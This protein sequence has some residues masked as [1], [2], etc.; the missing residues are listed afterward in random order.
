MI[1]EALCMGLFNSTSQIY[2][3]QCLSRGTTERG[4]AR[5]MKLTFTIGPLAAVAGSLGT[6]FV[7]NGG[8]PSLV[9]PRDF[10][11]LVHFYAVPCAAITAWCCSRFELE[12]IA[13]RPHSSFLRQL[14]AG[15]RDFRGS[16]ALMMLF[17]G[18]L[19]W[20]AA[21]FGIANL[22][23]YT[24]EAMGREPADFAGVMLA[25]CVARPARRWPVSDSASS[26]WRYE[27]SRAAHRQ[28][29]G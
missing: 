28:R 8:I 13:E 19:L 2:M 14:S 4:R 3:F 22:S 24:K 10:A 1:A 18:Y 7:L 25:P 21:L 29:W 20:N 17:F 6:Q 23:L 12:P 15:F 5:A 26:I 9:F 11:L 16:R 27:L